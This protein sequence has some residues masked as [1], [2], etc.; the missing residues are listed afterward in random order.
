MKLKVLKFGGACLK[1]RVTF[2]RVADI[3]C[4]AEGER[5]VVL[6]AIFGVTNRILGLLNGPLKE[7]DRIDIFIKELKR[8]H[9]ELA[10]KTIESKKLIGETLAHIEDKCQRLE[11]LLH[12][13]AYTEE[14]TEKTLDHIQSFGER[15]SVYLL[16][17]ILKEKGLKARALEADQIGLVTD[18]VF[19]NATAILPLTEKNLRSNVLPLINEGLVPVITGFFGCD[20]QGRTTTFGR[21]GSDYSAAVIANVLDAES[22]E[23]WKEVDGFMTADPKI[24]RGARRIESLSY[25]E[26][27]ELSYF[28]AKAL[29]PRAV[30]PAKLKEIPIFVRNIF[31]PES[32]GTRISGVAEREEG[33]SEEEGMRS[34]SSMTNLAVLRV[35]G[36]GAGYKPGTLSSIAGCLGEAKI[37]IYSATTSQTCISLLIDDREAEKAVESLEKIRGGMIEKVEIHKDSALICVVGEELGHAK[38][39]AARVFRCVAEAGVNV[40]WISAGASMVAYHFMVA[41]KDLNRTVRAVHQEFFER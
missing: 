29:H 3:V 26:A 11:R 40:E 38:G 31:H 30:E 37:N 39:L 28:G 34:V 20:Q 16:E 7:R 27:A 6:S 4:S 8:G 18:G 35:Y 19:G 10:M 41:R 24:V 21:D 12:G 2:Q 25:E 9:E 1:D 15:L 33:S 13:V 14:L 32:A 36:S 17:G 5:I 23:I 22:L